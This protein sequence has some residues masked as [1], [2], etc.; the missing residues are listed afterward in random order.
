MSSPIYIDAISSV[1]ALGVHEKEVF[2]SYL[3]QKPLFCQQKIQGKER[4]FISPISEQGNELL[5]SISKESKAYTTLDRTAL[6]AIFAAR[7][8]LKKA[9]WN[10]QNF[11][12]NIGSSRGATQLFEN[13]V[14]EYLATG[15]VSTQASPTT[16]LGNISSW[17]MQDLM[18]NGP[19]ISHSI[20]CSSAMHSVLNAI[21]WIRSG[22]TD[23]F[24][25]GGSEAP[26]TKFTIA[27]MKAL[28]LYA[29]FNLEET[30]PNKSLDFSKKKN[31]MILGEAAACMALANQKSENS[32]AEIIGFGYA[33]EA[34]KHSVSISRDAV[35]LQR[36]MTNALK[37]ANLKKVDAV[38]MHA[39][40]TVKGD[41]SELEAL[42]K[43]YGKDNLPLLTSNKYLIGHTFGSSGMMS[44][45]MAVLM[46]KNNRF[47][48]NPLYENSTEV[49]EIKSV[50]VNSVG[51][52]GNAVSI[53]ISK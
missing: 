15:K 33:N 51:F 48:E 35:C 30:Y 37:M 13:Y 23:Y 11:G 9:N 16:T 47:L 44:L 42:Q 28:K 41:S 3:R 22:L 29:N 49:K 26:L 43:V 32:L 52:G 53:I 25:A 34:L 50:M 1:S 38:V 46:L 21:A 39:P 8:T 36:S 20:T 17:V 31:T 7:E 18:A 6:L 19:E 2:Q 12:V 27:Q 40:G 4:E 5:N 10:H 14:Q 24:L 45:E